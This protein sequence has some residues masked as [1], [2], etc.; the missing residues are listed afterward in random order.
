MLCLVHL[1]I[2]ILTGVR[3]YLTVDCCFDLH[4]SNISNVEHL[5][6]C[7]LAIYMFSLEKCSS[8]EESQLSCLSGGCFKVCKWISFIYHLCA[9]QIGCFGLVSGSSESHK[10]FK[11]GVSILHS[12]LIFLNIIPIDFQNLLFMGLVSP[13]QDLRGGM[14]DMELWSV[15]SQG[16]ILYLHRLCSSYF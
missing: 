2:D 1:I 14:P 5:F 3:W 13:V 15:T 4:L 10:L 9:F 16:K 6:K 7:V 8:W 12:F 11:S